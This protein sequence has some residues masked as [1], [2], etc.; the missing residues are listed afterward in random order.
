M[1]ILFQLRG[2]CT[3][4]S[5]LAGQGEKLGDLGE[6]G[7]GKARPV[8][9]RVGQ[10]LL[11]VKQVAVLDKQQTVDHQGRDRRKAGIELLRITELIERSSP[12]ISNRQPCLNFLLVGHEETALAI[13]EQVGREPG[14]PGH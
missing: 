2:E 6:R 1:A 14:L 10:G 11:R 9:G 13:G 3:A 7:L 4:A 5:G 12:T 8:D